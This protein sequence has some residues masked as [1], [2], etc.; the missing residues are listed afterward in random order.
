MSND[1]FAHRKSNAALAIRENGKALAN[2]EFKIKQT[3]HEFL[4]GVGGFDAI[5]YTGGGYDGK[6]LS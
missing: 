3:G 1:T 4:F 6:A 2:Q 5:E